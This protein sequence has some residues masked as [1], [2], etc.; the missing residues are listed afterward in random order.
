MQRIAIL[1][2]AIGCLQCGITEQSPPKHR[3]DVGSKVN[4][5]GQRDGRHRTGSGRG[6]R[7]GGFCRTE[8]TTESAEGSGG[9]HGSASAQGTQE[10]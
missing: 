2:T 7:G 1:H 6:K 5:C 4:V 10:R 3:F 9:G 8:R